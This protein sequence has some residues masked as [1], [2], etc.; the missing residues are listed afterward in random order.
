MLILHS[1][2]SKTSVFPITSNCPSN[3]AFLPLSRWRQRCLLVT[4]RGYTLVFITPGLPLT[5]PC[6]FQGFLSAAPTL[7]PRTW[8]ISR[9]M[10]RSYPLH[11]SLPIF[12]LQDVGQDQTG[13]PPRGRNTGAI[14]G[15]RPGAAPSLQHHGL[16]HIA[17]LLI[18]V[19]TLCMAADREGGV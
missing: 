13:L 8:L 2:L 7:P 6:V 5:G 19:Q 11:V 1:P 17:H 18:A 12:C 4:F 10:T 3:G 14:M 16:W 15:N 9:G